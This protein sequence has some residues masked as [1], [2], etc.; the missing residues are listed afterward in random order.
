[1]DIKV[2]SRSYTLTEEYVNNNGQVET[3]T[4]KLVVNESAGTFEVVPGDNLDSFI[5]KS[6]SKA[7]FGK[8]AAVSKLTYM[9]V[10]LGIKEL[11]IE[12]RKPEDIATAMSND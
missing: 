6:R 5:Y 4:V 3:A 1:M 8:W 11:K 7:D 10:E 12:L 2:T 9:A